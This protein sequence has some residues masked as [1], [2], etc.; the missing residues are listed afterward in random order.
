MAQIYFSNELEVARR[1]QHTRDLISSPNHTFFSLCIL[2]KQA[3]VD[4]ILHGT[5]T[6]ASTKVR[7]SMSSTCS[8][9]TFIK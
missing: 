1:D 3:R 9:Q 4:R 5:L 8:P 6:Q 7:V 2:L